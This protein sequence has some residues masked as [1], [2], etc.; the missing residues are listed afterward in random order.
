ME[1]LQTLLNFFLKN[2]NL[3]ALTPL[4]ELFSSNGFDLKKVLNNLDLNTVGSV[5]SS[6]MNLENQKTPTEEVGVS[7]GIDPV[8]N[9]ASSE[10]VSALNQYFNPD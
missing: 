9:F 4:I 5:V 1:I 7:E 8:K 10:I 2:G 6:F 3:G